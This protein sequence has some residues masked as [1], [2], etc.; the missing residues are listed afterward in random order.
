M[1][2][3]ILNLKPLRSLMRE[4]GRD[5]IMTTFKSKCGN[6]YIKIGNNECGFFI[7]LYNYKRDDYS[8]KVSS[9]KQA[10]AIGILNDL[11]KQF[12]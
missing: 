9:I 4:T 10:E 8:I 2:I 5:L 3:I 6:F 11:L 1:W 7:A 12:C